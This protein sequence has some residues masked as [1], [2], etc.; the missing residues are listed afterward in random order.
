VLAD[1]RLP[2]ALIDLD[3]VDSN[4]AA[5]VA[6]LGA[7]S[8]TIRIASKSVRHP[9]LLRYLL[10][11]DRARFRGLLCY[12]AHEAAFLA[13]LGFEDLLVAYPV[14]RPDE[15]RA[16]ADLAAAGV[17]VLQVIDA[18]EHVAMLD[19]AAR[20]VGT[21][22]PVC[23][24]VDLSW[25]PGAGLHLGVRRSPVRSV[26]A[27]LAL[28]DAARAAPG[29]R[30]EAVLGYEAQVAG[31]RDRNPG[32][33]A[34]DPARRF[35]K[36]RS[37]RLAASRRQEIVAA[38]REAGCDL[39]IVN[40]GGTGSL[41]STGSDPSVTE[42]SAGS[43]FLGPH[44][45]DGY[46][47]LALRPAALFALGVCRRSDPDHVTCLG[48]GYVASGA[49]GA[50]RLPSVWLPRG[51]EPLSLEGWGEVQTPFRV[52]G[53]AAPEIG[54]PVLCRHAKAGEL[55]ERFSTYLIV[56][57]EQIVAREPTYRGFGQGFP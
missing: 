38:M 32:S 28:V 49:P 21:V 9:W 54:D 33:R 24:D 29:V 26:A 39:R 35:V 30:I 19:V 51:L 7:S 50:D 37:I 27:A 25:R 18:S 15:A 23:V 56:R 16:I 47:G 40:G 20:A 3:A 2:A 6:A 10:D 5:L 46:A 22:V 52:R 34:L 11:L 44:L 12:H 17:R 36:A 14:S 48:G 41:S 57:G 8:V 43:G 42:V 31:I 4:A 53:G 13:G 55:A 1:Q 45:F